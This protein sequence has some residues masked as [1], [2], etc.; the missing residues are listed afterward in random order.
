[1]P[2]LW[3]SLALVLGLL[4]GSALPWP[5]ELWLGA[6]GLLALAAWAVERLPGRSPLAGRWTVYQSFKKT[7]KLPLLA[8]A[9]VFFLGAGRFALSRPV[10]T[11]AH[12]AFYNQ[13]GPAAV[14]GV[15][16]EPPDERDRLTYVKVAVEQAALDGADYQPAGGLLL[17]QLE[18][19][20]DLAYGDRLR[21]N[22]ELETPPAGMDFSFREYLARKDVF[23]LMDHPRAA[24]LEQNA[25]N[26]LW[27]GLFALRE[28]GLA[29]LRQAYPAPESALLCG[30]LLGNDNNLPE[31]ISAAFK[32]TG[33]AHIIA[34]SGFN[35]AIVAALFTTLCG[36]WL[37]WQKGALVSA[38]GIAFYTLLVGA[39]PAVVRAAFMS[40][41]GLLAGLV[42]RRQS[43]VNSLAFAA[44]AM[45]FFEPDL[46]WDVSFQLSFAATLGLILYAEPLQGA[47]N[48]LAG[49]ILPPSVVR[50]I[51]GPVG[52][53]LLLTLAAQIT[54]LPVMA[55]HFRSVSLAA[56]LA[57]PL[58][59]PPQPLV[60]IWGG[61]S[62]L[63]GWFDPGLGQAA[64]W[65]TWPLTAYTIHAVQSLAQMPFAQLR[66]GALTP[67]L[68][69]AFYA[70]LLGLTFWPRLRRTLPRLLRP[71]GVIIGLLALAALTWR[72][73]A[74]APDG[75]LH[76]WLLDAN[77]SE[78]LLIQSPGGRWLLING[79]DEASKL[80]SFLGQR[81]PLLDRRLD[82]ALITPGQPAAVT[83]L[84]RTFETIPPQAVL[85]MPPENETT[86]SRRLREGLVELDVDLVPALAGQVLDLGEGAELHLL[87]WRNGR[88]L[89]R[90]NW[91]SFSALLPLGYQDGELKNLPP[92]ALGSATTL[93]AGHGGASLPGVQPQVILWARSTPPPADSVN[94]MPLLAA[95]TRG[96]VELSTDGD[97]LWIET[98][99]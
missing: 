14:I 75:R 69:A 37:G 46:P 32:V 1:M 43:G 47:F 36:R 72:T 68:V 16:A 55:F 35:M 83:A 53:Y 96:W 29:F 84:P 98:Q 54:T 33:T 79:G 11:P 20:K 86:A 71:E 3:A 67:G 30:I 17:V 63:L 28:R 41:M 97:Q 56:L 59:L 48:R 62:L 87:E 61:L 24:R 49:K 93:L 5:A 8:L 50:W 99:K 10:I 9:A 73:A 82:W 78:S 25:G 22:G 40:W 70:L 76:L 65:L 85:W 77:G 34:I 6:A 19:G 44:G 18:P 88:A 45:C 21:L 26:L 4:L 64:A 90:L 52:D 38:L 13:R 95:S 81:L 27:A 57:N 15:V 51:A 94:G 31:D 42:G 23:S 89:W 39:G 58:V 80:E 91:G 2:L 60:M 66:L 12:I 7:H 74:A 92:E